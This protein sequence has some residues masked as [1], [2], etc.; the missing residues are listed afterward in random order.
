[1]P[2]VPR[3]RRDNAASPENAGDLHYDISQ[4]IDRY[5]YHGTT[6]T[7]KYQEFN[8]VMGVLACAQAEVYRRL[9]APYE[10]EKIKENG[11]VYSVE[12]TRPSCV[13]PCACDPD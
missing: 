9:V 13:G 12:P 7:P 5:L 8:D 3:S 11:D 10:D 2:Y 4:C 1:M 6:D